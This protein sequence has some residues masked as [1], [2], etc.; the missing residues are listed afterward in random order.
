MTQQETAHRTER[1]SMGEV[2]VPRDA[3]FGAQTR[4]AL[5]NF[6]ISDL[7]KP[8]RF[9][10][11]CAEVFAQQ[12]QSDKALE[13]R[14][15]CFVNG[16]HS[17]HAQRLD[18]DEIIEGAFDPKL[19]AAVGARDS[20]ERI[21]LGYVNRRAARGAELLRRISGF[22]HSR[23]VMIRAFPGKHQRASGSAA[24]R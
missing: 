3:L 2:E 7:R 11:I 15:P 9:R 18:E 1:D 12:F 21:G 20:R 14:V 23:R 8:R 16:A 4:R 5:D 13:P 22:R 17:S 6:P 24:R 19:L 10:R